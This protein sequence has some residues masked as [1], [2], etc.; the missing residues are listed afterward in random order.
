MQILHIEPL[1]RLKHLMGVLLVTMLV[2][3]PH[4][5]YIISRCFSLFP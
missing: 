3:A 1:G 4:P 5:R 2:V